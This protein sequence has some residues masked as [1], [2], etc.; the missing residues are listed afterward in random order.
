MLHNGDGIQFTIGLVEP[1]PNMVVTIK[2]YFGLVTPNYSVPEAVRRV[3][4]FSGIL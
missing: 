1:S 3:K 4:V 2:L